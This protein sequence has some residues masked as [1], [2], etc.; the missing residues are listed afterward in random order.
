MWVIISAQFKKR[1][2]KGGILRVSQAYQ[3]STS[4]FFA[5]VYS[6]WLGNSPLEECGNSTMT[7]KPQIPQPFHVCDA[8]E[9]S[10]R[11]NSDADMRLSAG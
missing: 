11:F 4:V 9:Q 1:H 2:T 10:G 6:S 5:T 8:E 3:T 7:L